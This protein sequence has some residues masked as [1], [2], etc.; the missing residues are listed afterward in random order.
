MTLQVV[1]PY[2]GA[3]PVASEPEDGHTAPPERADEGTPIHKR[4][5]FWVTVAAVVGG[6]TAGVVVA[7]RG[8][9]TIEKPPSTNTGVTILTLGAP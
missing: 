7:T 3:G 9:D 8:E 1:S 4:W 5:W 6:V 2:E